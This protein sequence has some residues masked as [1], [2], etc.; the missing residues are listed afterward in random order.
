M[1]SL[2]KPAKLAITIDDL[3]PE[4]I[5]EIFWHL[6]PQDLVACSMVKN[7]WHLIYS[8]LKVSRLVAVDYPYYQYSQWRYPYRMVEEAEL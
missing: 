8:G 5:R 2:T 1:S 4:M 6:Q 3:P 7:C